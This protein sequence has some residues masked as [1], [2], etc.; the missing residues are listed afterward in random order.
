[1]EFLGLILVVFILIFYFIN[2]ITKK[3]KIKSHTKA[4]WTR[5]FLSQKQRYIIELQD[6]RWK[7]KRDKILKRDNYKCVKCGYQHK[8]QVH[9]KYYAH[10]PNN[11]PA[12]AWDY[13]DDAFITLCD[14]CHKKEHETKKIKSYYRR[15][16]THYS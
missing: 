15:F 7:I 13:P 11:Y 12:D 9:H 10:Y 14:R 1:M 8:L 6:D 2:D 5:H 16:G 3:T 4:S